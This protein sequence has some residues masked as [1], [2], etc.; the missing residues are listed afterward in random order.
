MPY[1]PSCGHEYTQGATSCRE[2][3]EDLLATEPRYCDNCDWE[4]DAEAEYC[5]HCGIVFETEEGEVAIVCETHPSTAAVGVC[6]ICGRP[7]CRDCAVCK[8]GR[9]F[10]N[11]NEHLKIHQNWA[12]LCSTSAEYEAEMVKANLEIAG[13]KAMV[14]S[15]VDHASFIP[16]SRLALVKVMVPKDKLTK[17]QEVLR[18]FRSVSDESELDVDQV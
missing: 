8:K 11:N 17:A 16:V 3:G 2:C 5:P 15:Q 4:I 18:Q 14:F 7:V 12:I 1:C 9:V 10:C 13:I 6:V